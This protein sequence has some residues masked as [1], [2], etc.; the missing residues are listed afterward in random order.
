VQHAPVL[1]RDRGPGGQRLGLPALLQDPAFLATTA[2]GWAAGATTVVGE[3]IKGTKTGSADAYGLVLADSGLA[4][5]SAQTIY[6]EPILGTFLTGMTLTGQTNGDTATQ[7][8][9][10]TPLDNYTLSL[11][12]IRDGMVEKARGCRG[13]FKLELHAGQPALIRFDF[14]G[15]SEGVADQVSLVPATSTRAPPS[16]SRRATSRWTATPS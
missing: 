10:T 1:H 12:R 3:I 14:T 2:A 5:G 13:T 15:M 4:T 9:G 8:G 11:A 7:D 6:L 16:G